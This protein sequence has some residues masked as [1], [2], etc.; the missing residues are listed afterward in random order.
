[1]TMT[2]MAHSDFNIV[3]L[4]SVSCSSNEICVGCKASEQAGQTGK[5]DCCSRTYK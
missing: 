2:P 1:M 3:T 4:G 5:S